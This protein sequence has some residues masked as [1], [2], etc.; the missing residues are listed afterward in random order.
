MTIIDNGMLWRQFAVAI[1]ALGD[2]LRDCPDE[3]WEKPLWPD[4]PEQ[5]VAVRPVSRPGARRPVAHVLGPAAQ[6]R[7]MTPRTAGLA[8]TVALTLVN[9]AT[10]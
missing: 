8:W 2:A 9:P 1:D 3:L 6:P 4:E 5:W 7:G 10:Q